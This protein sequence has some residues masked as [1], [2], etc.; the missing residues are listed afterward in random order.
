[1]HPITFMPKLSS[2]T[3]PAKL[4]RQQVSLI[5]QMKMKPDRSTGVQTNL[6]KTPSIE[7]QYNWHIVAELSWNCS[8]VRRDRL[9][10]YRWHLSGLDAMRQIFAWLAYARL[11]ADHRH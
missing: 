9:P 8:W 10:A 11:P 2:D 3:S 1:M 7:C 5:Y 6:L 4:S